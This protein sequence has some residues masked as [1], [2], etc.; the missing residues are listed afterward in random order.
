MLPLLPSIPMV[1]AMVFD[2]W[3]TIEL[4]CRCCFFRLTLVLALVLVLMLVLVLP[5]VVP[6]RWLPPSVLLLLLLQDA[7]PLSSDRAGLN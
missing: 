6:R 4:L 2:A 3:E 5:P 1:D 7:R